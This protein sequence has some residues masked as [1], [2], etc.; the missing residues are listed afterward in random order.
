MKY[1]FKIEDPEELNSSWSDES[2]PFMVWTFDQKTI[3]EC[4]DINGVFYATYESMELNEEKVFKYLTYQQNRGGN[5]ENLTESV[6]AP[7][8]YG[9]REFSL[10]LQDIS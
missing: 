8:E 6:L 1:Y 2:A 5:Q 3:D 4:V 9:V 7:G 10:T